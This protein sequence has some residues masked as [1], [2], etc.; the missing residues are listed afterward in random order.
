M[1]NRELPTPEE[2][3]TAMVTIGRALEH[4]DKTDL[5]IQR[6]ASDS[7]ATLSLLMLTLIDT[8][9]S[10]D[11]AMAAIAAIISAEPEGDTL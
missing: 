9:N 1:S 7:Y 5:L 6:Q 2:I 11:I 3:R 8:D 4:T 10:D